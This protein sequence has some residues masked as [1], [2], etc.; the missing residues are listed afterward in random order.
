MAN[1]PNP[2]RE[3]NPM[4]GDEEPG[5]TNEEDIIGQTDEE[6]FEDLDEME[7]DEDLEA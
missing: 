7:D 6:D 4:R 1:D 5:R 2:I 3:R